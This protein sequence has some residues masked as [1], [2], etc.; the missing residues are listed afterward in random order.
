MKQNHL[1]Q[2][3]VYFFE[4]GQSGFKG[5]VAKNNKL[6]KSAHMFV[7]KDGG[8][9]WITKPPFGEIPNWRTLVAMKLAQIRCLG[10]K[11]HFKPGFFKI[12]I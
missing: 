3:P 8:I 6:D 5:H 1:S 7:A 4:G 12:V 2:F 10:K 11:R 9:P